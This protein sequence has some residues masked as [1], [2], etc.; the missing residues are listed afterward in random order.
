[1][2]ELEVLARKLRRWTDDNRERVAQTEP[3]IP[4]DIEND[5]TIENWI[6][7][8]AIAACLDSGWSRLTSAA[9]VVLS[10]AIETQ[11]TGELLLHDLRDV[12][13]VAKSR[14]VAGREVKRL[15]SA[16]LCACLSKLEGR[17]WREFRRGRSITPTQLAQLLRPFGVIPGT[18]AFM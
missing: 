2:A 1:M 9:A 12:F 3:S 6:P 18:I 16:H 10:N 17:S 13:D 14:K 7:L 15:S 4:D 11:N 8:L 5:R